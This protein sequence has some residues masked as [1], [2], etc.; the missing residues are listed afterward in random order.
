MMDVIIGKHWAHHLNVM[1]LMVA[2]ISSICGHECPICSGYVAVHGAAAA[3]GK[4]FETQ[5]RV[6]VSFDCTA[7]VHSKWIQDFKGRQN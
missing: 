1:R 7:G 2:V 6:S 3:A 5:Q 4:T